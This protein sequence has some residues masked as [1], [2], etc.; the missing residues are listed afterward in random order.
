MF[1][2]KYFLYVAVLFRSH[3]LSS[4]FLLYPTAKKKNVKK[5]SEDTKMTLFNIII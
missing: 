4:C 5:G 1:T 2:E 3:F